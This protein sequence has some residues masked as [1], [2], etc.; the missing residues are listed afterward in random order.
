MV[1]ASGKLWHRKRLANVNGMLKFD[2]SKWSGRDDL[3]IRARVILARVILA[4]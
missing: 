1:N 4:A 2:E 3:V